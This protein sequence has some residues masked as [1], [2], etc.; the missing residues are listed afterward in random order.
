MTKLEAQARAAELNA[1]GAGDG[2]WFVRETSPGDYEPVRVKAPGLKPTAPLR[3]TTEAKPRP[4]EPDDPR[5]S[6][7]RNVGGPYGF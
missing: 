4:P 6:Y 3:T 1:E 7:D 5:T 2:T